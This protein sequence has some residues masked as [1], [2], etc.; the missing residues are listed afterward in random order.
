MVTMTTAIL[1]RWKQAR[2]DTLASQ[3]P[4]CHGR[5]ITHRGRVASV[6]FG[7]LLGA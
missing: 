1:A 4:P 7:L 2:P 3:T 6:F 5:A